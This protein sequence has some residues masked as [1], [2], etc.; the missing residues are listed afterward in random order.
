M[1]AYIG[2]DKITERQKQV[3]KELVEFRCQE[4]GFST[5]KLEVHRIKRGSK[6]GKYTPNN[7]KMVC[8]ECH[9]KFHWNELK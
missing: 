1:P 9:L 8:E 4:C 5:D 7:I 2:V 3:L 6:G